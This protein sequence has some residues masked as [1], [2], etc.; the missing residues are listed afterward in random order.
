MTKREFL[1]A[2]AMGTMNEEIQA[3]A[4]EI[5]EAID[6]AANKRSI[7]LEEKSNE[8]YAPFIEIFT[9]ALTNEP[10]TA[11]DLLGLFEGMET[12]SGKTPTVQF[13]SSLGTRVVKAGLAEKVDV[14]ITGKGTQKGYVRAEN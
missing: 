10:K 11:S 4:R 1:E 3:K 12:P 14:K 2:V 7:K 5:R 9:A 13:V 8:A 6:V